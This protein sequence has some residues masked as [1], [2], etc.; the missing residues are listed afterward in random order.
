[1]DMKIVEEIFDAPKFPYEEGPREYQTA[2]YQ[3]WC[4][5]DFQGI[6]AMATGTGKTI[7]AL[8]CVLEEYIKSP[9]HVYHT[10]IL[11]PTLTLVEQWAREAARFNFTEI[12]TISSKANWGNSI[13]TML[14]TA[15]RIRRP[16]ILISTY[17]SF[18]KNAFQ[19]LLPHFP[20][21]TILIADEAH[22]LAAPQI[23]KKLAN[24]P[25]S[26]RMGLSATPKR[27]YDPEGTAEMEAFFNDRE[28]YTFSFSME[29]A[30]KEEILCSYYYYP[31]IVRLH[32]LE[33]AEY[34][35]ISKKLANL[36][37]LAKTN[38]DAGDTYE[39]L[40]LA[41][42][43]IIHKAQDK[44]PATIRLLKEHLSKEGTLKYTLVYVPEGRAFDITEE[45]IETVDENNM[46]IDQYTREIGLLDE[47]VLVNRF[48]S[49]M[50][51][52]EEI[53][54]QFEKGLIDILVSMKCL[55]EGVDIPRAQMAIFCSSTGNPRQFIQRRGRILRKHTDKNY[56]VI[57]DLVVLPEYDIQSEESNTHELE[58]SLVKKELERVMYFASLSRNP[59]YA[60]DVFADVCR[61][62]ELNVYA[63][64]KELAI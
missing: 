9:K 61:I 25:L 52:R 23:V 55:D 33:M 46:I 10:L 40:L 39:K 45:G 5:N 26:R 3:N 31:W 36:Y 53:L 41:R 24:F 47:K 16:F 1:M 29:K 32:P 62:Y 30:I 13:A 63:I 37:H 38:L 60:E 51:D 34:T 50:T 48:V 54:S 15:K 57:H 6:F 11:A 18:I 58:K 27:I 56:A 59:Y 28:P 35:K 7:T 17:A 44:L 42:K 43:R 22:N 14:S 20:V 12:H 19:S 21:D 64:Q 49:G 8:N 4:K 2:A